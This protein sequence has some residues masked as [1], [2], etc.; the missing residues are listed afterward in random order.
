MAI[1]FDFIW[2]VVLFLFDQDIVY[3]AALLLVLLIHELGHYVM[4]KIFGYKGVR[5][6]VIPL[7]GGLTTGEKHNTQNANGWP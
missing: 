7:L 3:V 5:I 6:Y 1:S 2:P 4:M